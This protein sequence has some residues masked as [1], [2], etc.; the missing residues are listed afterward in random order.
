MLRHGKNNLPQWA[1]SSSIELMLVC[2]ENLRGSRTTCQGNLEL[3]KQSAA[4][5]IQSAHVP[6]RPE[7]C[8]HLPGN[9]VVF[10]MQRASAVPRSCWYISDQSI[11]SLMPNT[12][13][14]PWQPFRIS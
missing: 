11:L 10:R 4:A 6:D 13:D 12:I 1:A 3:V 9:T 5:Q 8:M 14:L 2:I 7:C